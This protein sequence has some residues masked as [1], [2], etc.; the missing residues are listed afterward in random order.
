MRYFQLDNEEEQLL[1]NVETGRISS[2]RNVAKEK[3]RFKD[4]ARATLRKTKNINIRLSE[5]DVQ[6]LKAQAFERG[7]PYQ[8]FIA[9][10][11]HQVSD[12]ADREKV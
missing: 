7:M 12:R 11:L 6:K 1:E 2:V 4:Y 3:E 5:R 9:S 8:T 10:V